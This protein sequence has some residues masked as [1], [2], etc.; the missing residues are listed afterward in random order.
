MKLSY[1][2]LMRVYSLFSILFFIFGALAVVIGG[3]AL[4]VSYEWSDPEVASFVF[5]FRVVIVLLFGTGFV[6]SSLFFLVTRRR[7]LSSYKRMIDRLSSERSMSF[8]LNIQF[9]EQDEFGD[10]GRWLNKFVSRMREFDRI[11][12]E[13]LRASQ[14]KL[15]ALAETVDKGI[16]FVSNERRITFAN[17]AFTKLLNTGEKTVVGLPLNRVIESEEIGLALEELEKKP[18]NRKLDDLRIKS[19]DYGYKT[20]VDMVPIIS[21]EVDLLETMIVFSNMQKKRI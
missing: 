21:P 7:G 20:T 15:A 16:L 11:K 6:V 8:N 18:K 12:V 3:P 10:L 17:K 14:Q 1:S 19:G 13:R 9:P 5:I 2:L 4:F